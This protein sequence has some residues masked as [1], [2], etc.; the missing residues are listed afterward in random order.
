LGKIFLPLEKIK[1]KNSINNISLTKI[2]NLIKEARIS[3]NQSINDLASDLKISEQQL[4]AIEEGRYDLLPERVFVKA[5]IKKIYEKLQ[6]DTQDLIVEFSNP[7]EPKKVEEIVEE[8]NKKSKTINNIN[9]T[10]LFNIFI[11][12]VIG[13]TASNYMFNL[14]FNISNER[15]S[16]TFIKNIK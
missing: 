5:M 4:Q 15:E 9:L 11:S 7:N 12:G 6:L 8:I 2:G 16:Q 3:K 10:F 14:I 1:S 13:F